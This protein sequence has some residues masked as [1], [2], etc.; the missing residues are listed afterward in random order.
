MKTELEFEGRK[1]E[2]RKQVINSNDLIEIETTL[3]DINPH[4]SYLPRTSC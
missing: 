3:K 4:C 1:I 2:L